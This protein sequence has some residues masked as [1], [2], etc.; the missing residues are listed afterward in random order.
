MKL[1]RAG[2]LTRR[3]TA[4]ALSRFAGKDARPS[5][6]CWTRWLARAG[7]IGGIHAIRSK[8][9]PALAL[10]PCATTAP[11]LPGASR[12]GNRS[13]VATPHLDGATRG[14]PFGAFVGS[15][16][17]VGNSG[18]GGNSLNDNAK[19][20]AVYS[21]RLENPSA[22]LARSFRLAW[23]IL[24]PAWKGLPSDLENMRRRRDVGRLARTSPGTRIEPSLLSAPHPSLSAAVPALPRRA[25]SS[26]ARNSL[27]DPRTE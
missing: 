2:A 15:G 5:P 23:K 8:S 3:P 4:A 25:S 12:C 24:P 20:F 22:R 6:A 26:A 27:S 11:N 17:L 16:R 14:R 21:A 13:A 7:R 1:G 9:H 19:R 18:S 10:T